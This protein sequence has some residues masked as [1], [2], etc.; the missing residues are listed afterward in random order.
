MSEK[1]FR[2]AVFGSS[3]ITQD[4]KAAQQAETLG[5][6][7]AQ[8]EF[9]VC[10]GGYMGAME[11][12]SRG[13]F[14][15][16][17]RVIGVTC[18]QFADRKPNPYL[19]EEIQTADLPERLITLVRLADAFVVLDGN[20]GTLAECFLAWNLLAMGE[21][22]PLLVVGEAMRQALYGLSRHTEISPQQLGWIEFVADAHDAVQRLRTA[23]YPVNSS[24]A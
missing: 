18:A 21:K 22:R 5:R 1:P 8:A 17:G 2:I 23:F 20:I 7:L 13:A 9:T 14:Q 19:S 3:S 4:S 6:F 24:R 11:A 16:G 10:N 15:A 12:C